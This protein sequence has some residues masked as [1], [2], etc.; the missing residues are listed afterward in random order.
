MAGGGAFCGLRD[1]DEGDT[2][3]YSIAA[4]NEDEKFAIGP[5]NGQVT[6]AGALD[7]E[8]TSS[9]TLTVEAS[10]GNGGTATVTVTITVT[11]VMAN[12]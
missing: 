1:A 11:D 2:I 6:V 4:G 12:Y 10:D 8:T 9:Y 7:Y 5:S 3:S